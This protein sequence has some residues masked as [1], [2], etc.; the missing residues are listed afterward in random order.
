MTKEKVKEKREEEGQQEQEKKEEQKQKEEE[1]P[2]QK[3]VEKVEFK[4]GK[5]RILIAEDEPHV[6]YLFK[7]MLS[8]PD[9]EVVGA[10]ASG[11]EAVEKY[12][13]LKPDLV[14]M[15]IM[16]PGVN[17][18]EATKEIMAYDSKAKVIMITAL[19]RKEQVNEAIQAGARDYIVK[20]FL[21][22]RILAGIK[23]V[24]AKK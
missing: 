14:L 17:G 3:P 20:P 6:R 21:E 13:K 7:E 12:K 15:D 1:K 10:V 11:K 4:T 16:M 5:K 8:G 23:R 22:E 2:E 19:D 24:L 18:I 9:Y